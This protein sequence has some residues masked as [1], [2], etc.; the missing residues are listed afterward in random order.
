MSQTKHSF[1]AQ[2]RT[3][4]GRKVKILRKSGIVPANIFG[5]NI[6][7][8]AIQ[9][10]VKPFSKFLKEVGE[11]TLLYLDLKGESDPRP[12]L[13]TE[14]KKHPV[15]G[16]LQHLSFLQVDLKQKVTAS[17]P[18]LLVGESPAVKEKLGILVQ[19]LDKIDVEALPTDIPENIQ[20]DISGL[21]EVNSSLKVKDVDLSSKLVLR[22]D[23]EA[24]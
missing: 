12:V 6:K 23:P 9:L 4:T 10:E 18:V 15:T 19:Q 24:I 17:V 16:D 13:L 2:P 11:S 5:K 3:V 20:L 1:P 7:S 8:T 22:S 21:T 14:K